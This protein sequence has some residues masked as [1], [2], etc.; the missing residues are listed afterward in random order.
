MFKADTDIPKTTQSCNRSKR[1][2]YNVLTHG[3]EYLF[4][5]DISFSKHFQKCLKTYFVVIVSVDHWEKKCPAVTTKCGINQ[6]VWIL[7][8]YPTR[9]LYT[10][11]R[12]KTN[13]QQRTV[14]YRAMMAWN[15]LPST[16]NQANSKITLQLKRLNM[17]WNAVLCGPQEE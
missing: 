15:S 1:C 12:S 8:E 13:P 2:F 7:S 3:Y 11:P 9:G 4:K 17:S 16:I 6:G 14:L 10:V 5:W